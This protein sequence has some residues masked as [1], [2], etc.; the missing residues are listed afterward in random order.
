MSNLV[1]RIRDSQ[2]V[3]LQLVAQGYRPQWYLQ[4][5]VS[6]PA[7]TLRAIDL[8]TGGIVATVA[9]GFAPIST[10]V[11]PEVPGSTAVTPFSSTGPAFH[12]AVMGPGMIH[13][14]DSATLAFVG[15]WTVPVG[16]AGVLYA[17]LFGVV[18]DGANGELIYHDQHTAR[19]LDSRRLPQGTPT[20]ATWVPPTTGPEVHYVINGQGELYV[21]QFDAVRKWVWYGT[22]T[23]QGVADAAKIMTDGSNAWPR[24]GQASRLR[25]LCGGPLRGGRTVD[26]D[27]TDPLN[28]AFLS[29]DHSNTPFVLTDIAGAS[30]TARATTVEDNGDFPL[31]EQR[32]PLGA[33]AVADPGRD[34]AVS[35]LLQA[36]PAELNVLSDDTPAYV[37][38]YRPVSF[39]VSSTP[40]PDIWRY[41]V[42]PASASAT[43]VSP[44]DGP[45]RVRLRV[46]A[47]T[48]CQVV[49]GGAATELSGGRA[50]QGGTPQS[51]VDQFT[52][53]VGASTYYLNI[54]VAGDT[55]AFQALDYPLEIVLPP[56]TAVTF[57]YDSVDGVIS[58]PADS[59]SSLTPADD[60]GG[61]PYP[62]PVFVLPLAYRDAAPLLDRDA[63]PVVSRSLA[64]NI[65]ATQQ[66]DILS[67]TKV[68]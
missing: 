65:A 3:G 57:T 64:V 46:R 7:R 67:L 22:V 19:T 13:T 18:F 47:M 41:A 40:S 5:V 24:Y 6:V 49:T 15:S 43:W 68:S 50:V 26:Y 36:L 34:V 60:D 51:G 9:L 55:R 52:L 29:A 28:P 37:F 17:A 14:Y 61:H 27:I 48:D 66:V 4:Y 1:R 58:A 44:A 59:R 11:I 8:R 2:A 31:I 39:S 63:R 30:A 53:V 38:S 42:S 16:N 56:S 62:C 21:M 33:V 54:S 32:Y 23:G 35:S 10:A 45:Y 12:V 20:F 25:I